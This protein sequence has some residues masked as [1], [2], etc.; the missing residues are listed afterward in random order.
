MGFTAAGI[1]A[2]TVTATQQCPLGFKLTAPNGNK[3]LQVF[4]Y[5]QAENALEVGE[6]AMRK[7]GSETY[8][9]NPATANIAN[10]RLIGVAQTA[11]PAG[12][13]GF[14]L[15]YGNGEV[16]ASD[17]GADQVNEPLVVAVT[18]S[19]GRAHK[20]VNSNAAEHKAIFGL[21]LENAAA[22]GGSLFTAHIN[23]LG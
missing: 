2:T 22:S 6:V 10:M 12:E 8:V 13:F 7:G 16:Q 23:C 18:S 11:I 15:S 19:T 9:A 20:Y 5:V 14:V 1:S 17:A 4:T 3:G 21:G